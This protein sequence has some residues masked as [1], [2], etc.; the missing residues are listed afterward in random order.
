MIWRLARNF[1]GSLLVEDSR[2]VAL[3]PL[4]NISLDAGPLVTQ[5]ACILSSK[6]SPV[7]GVL[8]S[9]SLPHAA[10][11]RHIGHGTAEKSPS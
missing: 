9:R 3:A 5:P 1:E 4:S 2:E 11:H 10:C 6:S 7:L 8:A